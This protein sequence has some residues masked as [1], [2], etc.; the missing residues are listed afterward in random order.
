MAQQANLD[1]RQRALH[2]ERNTTV[3]LAIPCRYAGTVNFLSCRGGFPARFLYTLA[4]GFAGGT[5][6]AVDWYAD[7]SAPSREL[8]TAA[9]Q[10]RIQGL[11]DEAAA[12]HLLYQLVPLYQEFGNGYRQRLL[13]DGLWHLADALHATIARLDP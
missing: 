6:Y 13:N 4:T 11:N 7:Q 2:A 10:S 12:A 1:D 8:V 9:Y 3:Q 5:Q